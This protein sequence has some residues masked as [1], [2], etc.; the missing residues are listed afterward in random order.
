MEQRKEPVNLKVKQYKLHKLN[1]RE[2]TD[3]GKNNPATGT[4]G[5]VTEFGIHVTRKPEGKEG[6]A[7]KDTF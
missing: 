2:E 6:K 7:G 3:L 4:S 1:N 5:A